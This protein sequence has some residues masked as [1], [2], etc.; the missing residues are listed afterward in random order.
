MSDPLL[1]FPQTTSQQQ[2]WFGFMLA[3][4][5][6]LSLMFACVM[7][8]AAVAALGALMLP[9]NIL[10]RFML[11]AWGV[12]QVVGFS[13]MHYPLDVSTL[14]WGAVLGVAAVASGVLAHGAVAKFRNRVSEFTLLGLALASGIAG[15]QGILLIANLTPLGDISEFA[16]SIK[17]DILLVDAIAFALLFTAT[18]LAAGAGVFTVKQTA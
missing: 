10:V 17:K 7:P 2:T 6:S 3:S 8:F 9:R 13:F 14:S 4:T 11:A 18:R 12:N 5:M 16:W 1:Q 15:F